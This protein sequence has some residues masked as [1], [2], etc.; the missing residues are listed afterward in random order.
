[1]SMPTWKKVELARVQMPDSGWHYDD[2]TGLLK[3]ASSLQRH[4][5]LR[6]LVVRGRLESEDV[7]LV[8]G[9]KLLEVMLSLGWTEAMAVHLGDLD[10]DAAA[11]VA[12]HLELRFEIDYAR[13]ARCVSGLVER[14][15]SPASLA[16]GSP[17]DADRIRHFATLARFDWALFGQDDGQAAL[18][19]DAL[20]AP[21]LEPVDVTEAEPLVPPPVLASPPAAAAGWQTAAERAAAP[22]APQ[23]A[24]A[25]GPA[26]VAEPAP[27]PAVGPAAQ[28]A[29]SKAPAGL[30]MALF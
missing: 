29:P 23:A 20:A 19:W 17:F 7:A 11:C 8:N 6:P 14:G 12:L 10:D 2:T 5:Q 24:A 9:H 28:P 3:L 4:G 22:E 13:L 21:E 25:P 27:S 26:P 16:S 18:D 1:M 30:Q 15:A